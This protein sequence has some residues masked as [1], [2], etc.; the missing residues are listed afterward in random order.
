[1]IIVLLVCVIYYHTMISPVNLM[2]WYKF[3]SY[4]FL[5]LQNPKA[6][7]TKLAREIDEYC[8]NGMSLMRRRLL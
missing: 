7:T 2:R 1:M 4:A 3:L 6:D 5:S 8:M